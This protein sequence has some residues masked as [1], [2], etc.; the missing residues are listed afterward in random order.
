[1]RKCL[2]FALIRGRSTGKSVTFIALPRFYRGFGPVHP[3]C[4]FTGIRPIPFLSLAR[5]GSPLTE[6]VVI[7]QRPGQSLASGPVGC[8]PGFFQW[9]IPSSFQKCWLGLVIPKQ[10]ALDRRE[11][12]TRP[13]VRTTAGVWRSQF[14][15]T[16]AN[17]AIAEGRGWPSPWCRLAVRV[18][19][20]EA[21]P[22]RCF[23]FGR[24]LAGTT[25]AAWEQRK[26]AAWERMEIPARRSFP[27]TCCLSRS[28]PSVIFF[29]TQ[30]RTEVPLF[31]LPTKWNGS[32]PAR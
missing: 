28:T 17:S 27:S 5:A 21:T 23:G 9:P 26:A 6:I 2:E 20:S 12:A 24:S 10:A 11:H 3:V 19:G 8:A 15:G 7:S 14:H 1:M 30:S 32:I 25:S 4:Q 16:E 31:R 13:G 18:L 22:G 29:V